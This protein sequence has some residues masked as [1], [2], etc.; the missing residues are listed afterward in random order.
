MSCWCYYSPD[1]YSSGTS[2]VLEY[3]CVL[4][5][6]SKGDLFLVRPR[7]ALWPGGVLGRTGTYVVAP[8]SLLSPS[9]RPLTRSAFFALMFVPPKIHGV[10]FM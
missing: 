6:K 4:P 1:I 9:C 7:A 10:E 8:R 5:A 2:L 3:E